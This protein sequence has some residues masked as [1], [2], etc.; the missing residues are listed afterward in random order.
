M[1]PKLNWMGMLL[2]GTIV[3]ILVCASHYRVCSLGASSI[4]I[5]IVEPLPTCDE[6]KGLRVL[7]DDILLSY[8]PRPRKILCAQL[9][10]FF[11]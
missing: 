1:Q 11:E 10:D 9:T 5:E 2:N 3:R 4:E 7:P 6:E 8:D